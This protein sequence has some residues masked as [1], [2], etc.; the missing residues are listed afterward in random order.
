MKLRCAILATLLAADSS[1]V[2]AASHLSKFH[3]LRAATSSC[4]ADKRKRKFP[5][6]IVSMLYWQ[7]IIPVILI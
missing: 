1:T 7:S 5:Y 4:S 3:G 6:C 2:S